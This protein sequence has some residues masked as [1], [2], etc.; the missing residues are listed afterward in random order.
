M[1]AAVLRDTPAIVS[2]P[3]Y[4]NSSCPETLPRADVFVLP[5]DLPDIVCTPVYQKDIYIL[6]PGIVLV[7]ACILIS[8]LPYTT[9]WAE[10]AVNLRYNPVKHGQVT[11]VADRPCSTFQ[12]CAAYL[13]CELGRNGCRG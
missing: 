8:A 3:R 12:R 6:T 7:H 10:L 2:V 9:L 5:V 1:R 13:S 4:R 11:R